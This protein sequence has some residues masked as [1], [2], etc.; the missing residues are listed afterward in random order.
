MLTLLYL[1]NGDW[2]GRRKHFKNLAIANIRSPFLLSS[3]LL[4]WCV[5]V[6]LA[7]LTVNVNEFNV[8]V[9]HAPAKVRI[10][11]ARV[12][13]ILFIMISSN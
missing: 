4:N 3:S 12:F 2:C 1:Q 8:D 10:M 6:Y 5:F 9:F 7:T 11:S 13:L